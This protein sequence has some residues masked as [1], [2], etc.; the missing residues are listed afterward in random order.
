[1]SGQELQREIA[2]LL[3]QQGKLGLGKAREL[4]GM[5]LIAF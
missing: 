5:P 2:V 3:Y 4:A 1:M